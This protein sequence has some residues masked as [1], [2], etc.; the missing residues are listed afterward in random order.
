MPNFWAK[1][2]KPI[3]AL[4]PMAGLTDSA[5]RQ[6]CKS[7]GA[8]V[9]YGEMASAAGLVY[10]SKKTLQLMRFNKKERP[11]VVQLFGAVPEH[12]A[13]AAR[14]VEEKIGPDGLDINFGCPVKKV[15]RQGAGA[16]LM[17]NLRLAREIIRATIKSTALPVSIKIRAGAS[18]VNAIE[19]LKFVQDLD[20]KAVMLHG[21]TLAQ[22][23]SGPV[24]W[25]II[26][27]ARPLVKGILLANGGVGANCHSPL[28]TYGQALLLLKKSG[29][30][31]LGI[32]QGALGRPWIFREVRSKKLEARSK[33]EIFKTILK[34]AELV[35][36]LEGERG[37]V[38]MRKHL[39]CYVRSLANA[40]ALRE[41]LVK[42]ESLADI[43][44]ILK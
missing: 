21:R 24:N 30:D 27:E 25:Q 14:I 41:K 19:F 6:I 29:A 37:I 36:K 4:A 31:G 28:Q 16:V 33:E 10:D 38:E 18:R 34:H 40:R 39:C 23:Q 26:K 2:E 5:F 17:D 32:G 1:L 15:Q 7:Y 3:Y 13:Q 20:I 44:R 9:V 22:G 42:V 35:E 43:K 8:D 12:F 11:Y